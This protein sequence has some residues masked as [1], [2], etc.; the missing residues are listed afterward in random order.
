MHVKDKRKRKAE[1]KLSFSQQKTAAP[2]E[3]EIPLVGKKCPNGYNRNSKGNCQKKKRTI[4]KTCDE[5]IGELEGIVDKLSIEEEKYNDIL[6]C[7]SERSRNFPGEKFDFLYPLLDDVNFNNKIAAKKEFHDTRYIERPPEDY[8]NIEEITNKLCQDREFEL[9]P[10]QKFVRNFLS[11]K[12]P[13]NSLL[14]YHGLGSGKTCSA[15]SVC[16]QARLYSKQLKNTTSKS[17]ITKTQVLRGEPRVRQGRRRRRDGRHHG[18]RGERARRH[19]LRGPARG[20]R[21]G[22]EGRGLRGRRVGQGRVG[23]VR[24]H[25]GRGR[26]DQRRAR[27]HAGPRQLV[28]ARGRLVHQGQDERRGRGGFAHGR[29]RVRRA[30]EGVGDARAPRA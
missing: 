2:T 1:I 24:A 25:L 21:R 22:R 16:E 11:Y 9:S 15:I 20:R 13:Y 19:R 10:H 27:G 29:G 26:R 3:D 17:P 14:L 12:T 30:H 4:K 7:F 18:L 23:R 28:G 5:M 8:E 6:K